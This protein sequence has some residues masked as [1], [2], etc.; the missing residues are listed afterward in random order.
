MAETIYILN[1]QWNWH[2][3]VFPNCKQKIWIISELIQSNLFKA[4]CHGQNQLITN[5][6]T[7]IK[8]IYNLRLFVS[9]NCTTRIFQ[10][11]IS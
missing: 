9:E 3:N 8:T 1:C 5:S 7:C 2:Y 11:E 10:L 6:E 4:K